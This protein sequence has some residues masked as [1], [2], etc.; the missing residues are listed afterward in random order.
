MTVPPSAPGWLPRPPQPPTTPEELAEEE[1]ELLGMNLVITAVFLMTV[2]W[3]S[4]V[5]ER[6]HLPS[7]FVS[8]GM[9][10]LLGL[11]LLL[12]LLRGAEKS[13]GRH[14]EVGVAPA[15]GRH[16]GHGG[17]ASGEIRLVDTD[18]DL[19]VSVHMGKFDV[20]L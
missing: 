18:G 6:R 8:I 7:A 14:Q 15:T 10:A 2:I 3:L 1:H 17:R 5:A 13:P 16:P 4:T 12:T 11:V 20:L 19:E 9:G